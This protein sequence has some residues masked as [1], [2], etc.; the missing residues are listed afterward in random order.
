[1]KKSLLFL[2]VFRICIFFNS[3]V[4]FSQTG[5]AGVGSSTNNV[6]WLKADAGT[7]S[8]TNNTAISFWNDQSGNAINVTQTVS[9]Q[10]PSF[11]T[12]VI[13]G[14]PAVLFDNSTTTNQNDKMI[15][16]D[17]PLLDNT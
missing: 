8:T 6:L 3:N 15:G 14:F 4:L 13:N 17:S 5:P 10:Q 11:A 7:S 1:M 12:S 2:F 16:P 9:I